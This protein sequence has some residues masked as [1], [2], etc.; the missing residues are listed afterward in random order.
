MLLRF[1]ERPDWQVLL[2]Q[3]GLCIVAALKLLD[4]IAAE[5]Q[6]ALKS[7][8]AGTGLTLEDLFFGDQP[9]RGPHPPGE[10]PMP[11]GDEA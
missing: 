1:R 5:R 3:Q 8:A 11:P 2:V 10:D 4:S 9:P 7:S 6:Q